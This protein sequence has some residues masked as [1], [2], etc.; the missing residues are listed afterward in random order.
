MKNKRILIKNISL[1]LLLLSSWPA[2]AYIGPGLGLGALG[3]IL[4][5]LLSI[6]LAIAAIFWYPIKRIFR[7]KK[8]AI[9]EQETDIERTQ[10]RILQE[11]DS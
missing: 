5:L 1:V 3:V 2:S 7:R 9:D 11:E 8:V 4:G 6:I 10:E